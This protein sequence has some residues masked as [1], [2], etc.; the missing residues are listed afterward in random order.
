[1]IDGLEETE[2]RAADGDAEGH[3]EAMTSACIDGNE[4]VARVAHALS[5]A[6]AIYPITPATPMGE[7]A[8]AW[9]AAGRRNLWG[10]VPEVIEMQSEAGAA[11]ALHGMLQSGA[12]ATTFT[13]SQGLL[14]MIPNLFKIAGELTP[15]VIHVAAR[16]VATHALSIF[17]D[18]SDVMAARTTGWAM[19]SASSVQ[20][21]HDFALVAHAATL[22]SRVPFLHFFDGY[23]TSHEVNKIALLGEAD[24]RALVREGDVLAHRARRLTPDHPV[25]R[26]SAQNPDVF[27]QSREAVNPFYD[28]VPGI[29]GQVMDE[30]AD[31]TGRRY[32]VVDYEGDEEADRVVVIMGSG[33]GAVSETVRE[34]VLHGEKVGL[35]TVRLFRP[36]PAAELVAALPKSVRSI[37]VFDRTKEPGAT[38]E[39]LYLDVR[40]ALAEAGCE[41]PAVILGVRYGLSSKEFTPSMVKGIFDELKQP[42]HRPHLTV[43]IDDDVSHL[44]V[45]PDASFAVPRSAV[46][47]VFFG[48]GSDGTVGAARSS[49]KIVGDNTDLNVQAYFVYD[50]RKAGSVTVSHLR[51][52]AGPIR[53]TYLIEQADF[54][55]CHDFALLAKM[56]ILDIAR[57]G[58]TFLLNAPYP[59][60][61]VWDHLPFEV[62]QQ[63]IDKRLSFSAID[64]Y[65]IAREVGLGG[66]VN[67][68]MQPCFFALSGALPADEAMSLMKVAIEKAYGRRGQAMVDRNFAAVD[69]ALANL[70]KIEVPARATSPVHRMPPIAA[71]APVFVR[72]VTSRLLAGEGDLL[73]VSAMPVDGTFPTGTGRFERRAIAQELP[74]WDEDLCTDC[75]KCAIVCPHAAIRLKVYLP[76]A[77]EGAPD[78]FQSKPFRSH[79]LPG[80]RLSVQVAPDDCTGCGLCVDV[81]PALSKTEIGHKSLDLTPAEPRRAAE[82]PRWDFF[83]AIPEID[84]QLVR[85]DTV[86]GV[87]LLQPLFEFS[88]ACSGCGETPYLKLL[89]Q[90]FGDRMIVANATGCSSIFGGN[91]PTTP[92]A[93]D[94]KG[95]GPAWANSLFE[96]NAEFGL[97]LRL[98][99]ERLQAEARELVKELRP[100]IGDGL[101]DGLL[102]PTVAES[103]D[104]VAVA[105]QRAL[106]EQL[107][108]RLE[109]PVTG[110]SAAAER[111]KSLADN[112]VEK[113]VWIV[114]GDGWAYD[115]G[116]SG[117]DHV[118]ASGRNVNLLVLDTE[119]YSNTGGQASKATPRGATAK[120]ST[121][122]KATSK[123][124]LGAVARGYGDVYVAQVALGAGDLQTVRALLEAA[125]WPG[126]SL[127]IAYCTCI[128]HGIDMSTSMKHQKA[129]VDSGHWPLYRYH[130][131]PATGTQ[132]FQLDSKPPSIPVRDFELAELRFS[133]LS[134]DDPEHSR[135]LLALAQADV[136]ERWQYYEQLA[137]ETRSV[138]H[139]DGDEAM[140]GGA[141]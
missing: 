139:D 33:A 12:L 76:E 109:D 3:A 104:E 51:F 90:L 69:Q 127:V 84:R 50:S 110:S 65:S 61:E 121:S 134:H 4:A 133:T 93:T 35:L 125:A 70:T 16:A 132:P 62:Q 116:F 9:S 6:I 106:V 37:A 105:A 111:L 17:G 36:F 78:G 63:I 136:D 82:R 43:G 99:V 24:L 129:A 45:A 44:S 135:H 25:L 10:V 74:V 130:P 67:T 52:D 128:A 60:A 81:C 59:P 96:D 94:D 87:S 102:A 85:H 14:L 1:M 18:H 86:K 112:L 118:L 95:R 66:R 27:F 113:V 89:S 56:K 88:G 49:A 22:R 108:E 19:L 141:E 73:P 57:P 7:H 29:V 79:D 115:I 23:R 26:G 31:R 32:H 13:A 77:L 137:G 64:A 41:Q 92:W 47:A 38:G 122:G 140:D 71:G 46:Q 28:A 98:G 42:T 20:E 101:A 5:E 131:S 100:M 120:F 124:D 123:K 48:L 83:R 75:G 55:A 126:P 53:S 39:P 54:V 11:G 40:T 117:L 72:H 91:L 68:V 80:H 103:T 21:A 30:L 15:A 58:A 119:V 2:E 107:K 34:L 8:D 97:G 138:P 114:G